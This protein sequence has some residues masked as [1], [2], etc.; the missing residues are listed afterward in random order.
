MRVLVYLGSFLLAVV[1]FL[2]AIGGFDLSKILA[3]GNERESP[4]H[5]L[6]PDSSTGPSLDPD[7]SSGRKAAP[8]EYI[9]PCPECEKHR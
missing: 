9:V 4:T 1:I 8:V 3:G 7:D 6:G 5:T 2:V